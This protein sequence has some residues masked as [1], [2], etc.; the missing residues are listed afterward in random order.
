MFTRCCFC[1]FYI[2]SFVVVLAAYL[3][4]SI[5]F[6]LL[7]LFF[8]YHCCCCIFLVLLFLSFLYC[9]CW[10]CCCCIFLAIVVNCCCFPVLFCFCCC[11][12]IFFAVVFMLYVVFVV[13]FSVIF[14]CCYSCYC[15]CQH[16]HRIA[17]PALI[18]YYCRRCNSS[19]P[20]V[21]FVVVGA[22]KRLC[23]LPNRFCKWQFSASLR[24]GVSN[25][26]PFRRFFFFGSH[27]QT[28]ELSWVV[29]CSKCVCALLVCM[30]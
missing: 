26:W 22:L 4:F 25:W 8:L 28:H 17:N 13:V 9:F 12:V 29:S 16:C 5:C 21:V 18:V 14:N 6:L 2:F 10:C 7:F 20:F 24:S 19:K 30:V 1:L 23:C 27:M 11:F 15:I 3:L